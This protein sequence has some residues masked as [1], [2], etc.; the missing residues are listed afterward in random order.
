M[1]MAMILITGSVFGQQ[2]QNGMKQGAVRVKFKPQLSAT[3]NTMKTSSVNGVLHTG[4]QAFDRVNAELSAVSMQR[5]FPYSAKNEAKHKKYGLDMWYEVRYTSTTTSENAV[6]SYSQL[7]EVGVAELIFEK[8]FVKGEVKYA[9]APSSNEGPFDDPYLGQQWHYNNTGALA[10]STEGSDINLYEGWEVETGSPDVVVCI[11]DG[12]IDTDH[13][14][15]AANMWINAAEANGEEG[16]D[17]DGNGYI[18]DINGFNFVTNNGTISDHYHGTHVA[19]TVAAVNNNNIGVAGIA[20]GSG[21]DDG[22]RLMSSQ[23]FTDDGNGDA[24]AAIVYGADNGAVISQNSWG[25]AAPGYSEQ[26]ILDAI[27][28]FVAEAGDYEGSPMK[29]G[30]VFFAAGNDGQDGEYYPGYY[31]SAI[32]V[33]AIG[34]N[35]IRPSYSN[36]GSWIDICAP[37]G[38]VDFGSDH[39]VL[40]TL[41]NHQYGSMDGTSMACPH[42]TGVAALVVSKYG[43][44]TFTNDDL[45]VHILTG[46]KDIDVHNPDYAGKMGKGYIDAHLALIKDNGIAPTAIVDLALTGIAQDFASLVWTVPADEDD[47]IPTTFEILYS[48]EEITNENADLADMVS[49]ELD[50][51]A[52][53]GDNVE[54]DVQ[55]LLPTTN[56]YFVIRSV[57]RWG[58]LSQIS[59][60]ATGTTNKG[61][62]INTDQEMMSFTVNATETTTDSGVF[63]ILNEDEG[64]L[65]WEGSIRHKTPSLS[66]NSRDLNYPEANLS[67]NSKNITVGKEV[68]TKLLTAKDI[69]PSSTIEPMAYFSDV[70]EYGSGSGYVIGEEDTTFTNSSATRFEVN[71]EIG[72]NLT[73]AKAY[74]QHTPGTGPMIM[75]I[76]SGEELNKK[77][78]V[79]AQEFTSYSADPYWH[80]I[81]LEEHLFFEKGDV[82]WIVVHVPSG[83]LYPLG[84]FWELSPEYSENCLMSLDMGKSWSSLS[85]L[86]EDDRFVWAVSAT[87]QNKHLGSYITLDPTSGV[88]NGNDSQEVNIDID[89]T[90]LINGMYSAN[91][92]LE[93]NDAENKIFRMPIT[94]EVS[95]QEPILVNEKVVDFGGVFY[96]H[97]KELTINIQNVGYG[98][99]NISNV[100]STDDQFEII[101]RPWQISARTEVT[102][103]IKYTPDGAGND[104]GTIDF[105]DNSGRLHSVNLFGVAA[106]PSEIAISPAK[107]EL[108]DLDLGETTSTSFTITNNGEY[109]LEYVIP[110]FDGESQIQGMDD[111][112]KFG[113][114]VESNVN[115]D[116]TAVFTWNDID[117]NA[118]DVTEFFKDVSYD[119]R[120][121]EADLGFEFPFYGEKYS[122][123]Y[124]T[125]YG[126]LS[127][128]NE[129]AMGNCS[130]ARMNSNCSPAGFISAYYSEFDLNKKGKI[131]YI[132]KPGKFIVEYT[133]V[134]LRYEWNQEN[135]ISMQIIMYYNGDV[136]LKYKDIDRLSDYT[137]ET[138]LIGL[139]DPTFADSYQLHGMLPKDW[140]Y[141]DGSFTNDSTI[142]RIKSPGQS[143]IS[144]V[145]EP[146][147]LIKVGESKTIA[148]EV[149]T[150]GMFE[151]S[152]TQRLAIVSNDPFT[153]PES[154]TINV[155]VTSG[156]VVDVMLNKT[157]VDLGQVFQGGEKHDVV[158]ISNEGTKDV[159]ITGISHSNDNFIM[160]TEVPVLLKAKSSYFVNIELSTETIGVVNDILIVETSDGNSFEAALHGEVIPAPEVS[161]NVTSIIDTLESGE[162]ITKSITITNDGDSDLEFV[163]SGN[164]WLYLTQPEVMSNSLKEFSY[165]TLDSD[166]VDGPAYS[167]EDI[168]AEGT[169]ISKDHWYGKDGT[170]GELF[171][172]VPMPFEFSFYNQVVDTMWISWQGCISFNRPV[173]N[174]LF[175]WPEAIPSLNEPN[176]MIAP[177]FALHNLD[178]FHPDQSQVGVF[179]KLYED[180]VVVEWAECFDMFG[181]GSNYNF[182]AILYKSGIIKFQYQHKPGAWVSVVHGVVGLENADGTEGVQLA[183]FQDYIKNGLAVSLTPA[184]KKIIP[185]GESKEFTLALDAQYLNKGVYEGN[186][187][188]FNNTPQNGELI[189]PVNLAV[190]GEADLESNTDVFEFGDVVAY[191]V[192]GDFGPEPFSYVQEF[193]IKNI[194]KDVVNFTNISMVDG[195]QASAEILYKDPWM[196][197]GAPTW[198]AVDTYKLSSLVPGQVVNLQ[199]RL[200]PSGITSE[201][202]D[203]VVFAGNFPDGELRL[204]I[205]ASVSLPAAISVAEEFIS[206]NANTANDEEI[207]SVTIDNIDGLSALNYNLVVNFFREGNG[208]EETSSVTD[209]VSAPLA[210]LVDVD[211]F[212][213]KANI[214]TFDHETYNEVLEHD[215]LSSPINALGFGSD[216]AFITGTA[217]QAPAIG[218]N[219]T[220]VKTWYYYEE[221]LDSRITVEIRAGGSSVADARVLTRESFNYNVETAVEGGEYITFELTENQIFYPGETFYV[222]FEYPLGVEMPQ[223]IADGV[224]SVEGRFMYSNGSAWGDIS[225]AGFFNE[226]WM[227]KAME[228]EHKAKSWVV[229]DSEAE[230]SVPAGESVTVNLKF[231]ASDAQDIDNNAEL[232]IVSNDPYSSENVVGL[233][234]HLNQG[235][236]FG[237]ETELTVNESESL[238]LEVKV[239]DVEGDVCNY[240]L[241][242]EYE[243]VQ[244][245][246]ENDTIISFVYTPDFESAGLNTFTLKGVDAYGNESTLDIPV[247]VMNVNRAPE[248][249]ATIESREYYQDEA[250]DNI[251]MNAYFVDPDGEELSFGFLV[252]DISIANIYTWNKGIMIEPMMDGSAE[253]TVI[254]SDLEGLSTES[255]FS[256]TIGTITGI[257]DVE[258]SS[259]TKVYPVPTS[260]PLNIVLGND[261]EGEVSISIINVTGITQYQTTVNKMSGEHIE[262]LNIG[263]M[264]SGIYLVKITSAKGE[265]VKR[266]VKM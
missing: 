215:T 264:A 151:S 120:F 140:A 233:S 153:N 219:L 177:Y 242:E 224:G 113:Y 170:E 38:N 82:F 49:L 45:K 21:N 192:N 252:D 182:E 117:S 88:V 77:S 158:V 226:G 145:S 132:R 202:V 131:S 51:D 123:I 141:L 262:T 85:Q 143:L 128:V 125:R 180:R 94:F 102:L 46:T 83:N 24:A 26:A 206:V 209:Y 72:F 37:G 105:T 250:M 63:T 218:F 146:Y 89:G 259:E 159:E 118:K 243:L 253:L 239:Q 187:R 197:W 115:G 217:F 57:D 130:P 13:E 251:D 96:G 22:V 225:D 210:A 172:A 31:E 98:N 66:Y 20:G 258:G 181:M 150:E 221:T 93:S 76:Y 157:E 263:H 61:P 12:G 69:N 237:L 62:A 91:V 139:G 175:I 109:P 16:V 168:R 34:P 232:I 189:L 137:R 185:A 135:T 212:D 44:D 211:G 254:A 228:M 166:D 60:V 167:W 176:N 133:D 134:L 15:L 11:V 67:S 78:M 136:E 161:V 223:G 54:F 196:M 104:N 75:E 236:Q 162:M 35:F 107:Q 80:Y 194:G 3:V 164:D 127:M 222:V 245:S 47:V 179:Y 119:H 227:V 36:Y 5:V 48:S 213:Y 97:D 257:E 112:H 184:E 17:D 50:K 53:L 165:Y 178:P 64:V 18:D 188:I 147:G 216:M 33:A 40:S 244:M 235:P 207:R 99:F 266:V 144:S 265:I 201:V 29:G 186:F 260:G 142:Y 240:T 103:T 149:S 32:T 220:H 39:G 23:I 203:T 148:V 90:T 55:E 195:T 155:D 234:L 65:K 9:P 246:V 106:A 171:K 255:T 87:S 241:A 73:E 204:P 116:S 108:E 114:S 4:I 68:D 10:Y 129:G 25:Y 174:P 2:Y 214:E 190:N 230:G 42:V 138:A 19:G 8:V 28:Y 111:I 126:L 169:Q 261:I 74:L 92:V 79:Y 152:L 95:G 81:T 247:E 101:Q 160:S 231:I 43:S 84:M 256:L 71:Q 27:D 7:Q 208:E 86:I 70:M 6:S 198:Q 41:P 193:F 229:L 163:A 200:F 56:Y 173:D 1:L 121:L 249:V 205:N 183:G 156:G 191:S 30:V 199:M 238:N 14:D 59:N 58:N 110:N 122:K 52:A 248:L 100:V 124:L 154:F